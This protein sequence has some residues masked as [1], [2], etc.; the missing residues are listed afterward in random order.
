MSN[1]TENK[2]TCKPTRRHVF[3]TLSHCA[4]CVSERRAENLGG[5]AHVTIT[6]EV[7]RIATYSNEDMSLFFCRASLC[8]RTEVQ[9]R[10]D[11]APPLNL[12]PT[13][14]LSLSALGSLTS[15][16]GMNIREAAAEKTGC[17]GPCTQPACGAA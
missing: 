5:S 17:M 12:P 4:C 13:P 11:A 3:P 9:Q 7:L 6:K 16:P 10:K 1:S 15:A 8:S 2:N 14:T